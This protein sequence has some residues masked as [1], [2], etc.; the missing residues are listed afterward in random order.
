MKS[1][2]SGSRPLDG[3]PV[4]W[5]FTGDTFIGHGDEAATDEKRAGSKGAD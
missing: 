2:R 3:N 4:G 1:L 5:N